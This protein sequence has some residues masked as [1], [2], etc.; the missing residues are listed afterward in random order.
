[1]KDIKE[2]FKYLCTMLG[3][4]I[5][6]FVYFWFVLL[7]LPLD[8]HFTWPLLACLCFGVFCWFHGWLKKVWWGCMGGGGRGLNQGLNIGGG[9]LYQWSNDGI[10][11]QPLRDWPK[12]GGNVSC[13]MFFWKSWYTLCSQPQTCWNVYS[14][15]AW[16]EDH[17]MV[18]EV[19][20]IPLLVH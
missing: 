5:T 11:L 19:Q 14:S 17:Q 4:I 16:R 8:G 9:G 10:L 13:H 7:C 1:M 20:P 3:K 6:M 18:G 12:K 15:L 2:K